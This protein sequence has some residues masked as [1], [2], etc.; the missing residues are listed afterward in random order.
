MN[1]SDARPVPQNPTAISWGHIG[2]LLTP[3]RW[4][5]SERFGG[6]RGTLLLV[7]VGE[8]ASTIGK[9]LITP[10]YIA[11]RI[12]AHQHGYFRSALKGLLLAKLC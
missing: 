11:G 7:H 4:Y 6:L 3:A 5:T 9:G 8:S 1:P 12:L 2:H 10:K